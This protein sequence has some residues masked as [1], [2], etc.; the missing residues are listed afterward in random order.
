MIPALLL[1]PALA[2]FIFYHL[3]RWDAERRSRLAADR[4]FDE[5]MRRVEEEDRMMRG[6]S[7]LDT[8]VDDSGVVVSTR[9][10]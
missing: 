8:R 2:A 7:Y 3:G 10:H 5:I 9:T 4:Q 6:A 1:L